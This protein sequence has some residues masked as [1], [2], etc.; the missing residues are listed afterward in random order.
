[1]TYYKRGHPIIPVGEPPITIEEE[2]VIIENQCVTQAFVYEDTRIS[3]DIE[4]PCVKCNLMPTPEGYD[5]CI[6]HV[7]GAVSVCC[8]HGVEEPIRVMEG[9]NN[10]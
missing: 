6:G 2:G 9:E 4:R 8:G 1:M 7:P 3:T 10:E 5:P